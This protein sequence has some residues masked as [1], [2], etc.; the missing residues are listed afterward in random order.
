M[1]RRSAFSLAPAAVD[2]YMIKCL[3]IGDRH[4]CVCMCPKCLCYSSSLGYYSFI[5]I[6]TAERLTSLSLSVFLV[7]QFMSVSMSVSMS[8]SVCVC[9]CV[10]LCRVCVCVRVHVF[11]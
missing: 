4:P 2:L 10:C 7:N 11:V 8:M 9:V 5:T 6:I 1:M 3:T